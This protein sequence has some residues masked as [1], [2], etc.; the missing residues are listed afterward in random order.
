MTISVHPMLLPAGFERLEL[1]AESWA[2][3]GSDARKRRR[4]ASTEAVKRLSPGRVCDAQGA[5][6]PVPQ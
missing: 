1:F 3:G 2:V 6:L 4:I 5:G